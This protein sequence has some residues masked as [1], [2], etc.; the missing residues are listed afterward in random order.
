MEQEYNQQRAASAREFAEQKTTEMKEK[1]SRVPPA[2]DV[3]TDRPM[4]YENLIVD[5]GEFVESHIHDTDGTVE[6]C[7]GCFPGGRVSSETASLQAR[8]RL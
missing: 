8:Y 4:K 3:F 1:L 2:N 5:I 6:G 7:P